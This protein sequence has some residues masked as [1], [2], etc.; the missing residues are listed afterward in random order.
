MNTAS[1]PQFL[2]L[3]AL[4]AGLCLAA[5]TSEAANFVGDGYDDLIVGAPGEAL[6]VGPRS[7]AAF[8]Y[9]GYSFGVASH[10][11]IDQSG[12]D[13]NELGDEF[14]SAF[15]AGDFD[16]DGELDL[17]IGAPGEALGTGP[18]SGAVFV[19]TGTG[20]GLRPSLALDQSGLGL[21][22][23]GD[24]FGESM[25]AADFNGDGFD[26]LAVGAP[27][28]G[29]G[30]ARSVGAVYLFLGSPV[31]LLPIDMLDQSALG[32][33]EAGDLFASAL[34]AGDFDG[35][36]RM[37]LAVGAPGEA[38]GQQL[39]AG[40]VYLF[41]GTATGLAPQLTLDQ[42]GLGSSEEGD[43]FGAALTS[44]DFDGDGYS[45]LAIGAPGKAPGAVPGDRPRAGAVFIHRGSPSS[46]QPRQVLSQRDLDH[47]EVGD[48]FGFAL[49]SGDYNGD[50]RDD[51]AVGAPGKNLPNAPDS[52]A[53]YVFRGD[54][55]NL[56]PLQRI[57][58]VGMGEDERGDQFGAALA[59]ANY[60]G[61]YRSDLA[62][63][64][65]GEARRNEAPSGAVYML[66]GI[67]L[68]LATVRMVDQSQLEANEP[69]DM[70]GAALL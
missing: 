63:G 47:D 9:R 54:R 59:S 36:G 57:T 19:Y 55:S 34:A 52:G 56:V 14:G 1:I 66:R 69:G 23:W 42:T 20:V 29:F 6:G 7:G 27:G 53:V 60:L 68:G 26:D 33:N 58:Q 2:G 41:R 38:L 44:G 50:G 62:I 65:P 15:A 17:A 31:G 39:A 3:A 10:G 37:D 40:Q 21:N 25:V 12:L 4:L 18:R 32:R 22:E 5:G 11:I 67:A 61:D 43:L 28:E 45:D 51:L 24:R 8:I 46:L 70:F 49:S 13:I 64:A 48:E 16:G 35:D 30:P